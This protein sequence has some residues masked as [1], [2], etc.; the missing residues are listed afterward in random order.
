MNNRPITLDELRKLFPKASAATIA[1][2]APRVC[3]TQQERPEGR[4]LERAVEREKPR[5]SRAQI[6]FRVYAIRPNDWDN[7]WAK[8]LQDMLIVS[9]ILDDDAWDTLQGSVISEKVH[10]PEEERT[11]IEITFPQ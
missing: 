11:E 4:P 1:A 10:R 7:V 3:P 9:G 2:N 8:D 6:V 5:R